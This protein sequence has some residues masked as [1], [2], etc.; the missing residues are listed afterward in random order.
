MERKNA[1]KSPTRSR[2][3]QEEW[4]RRLPEM[5]SLLERFPSAFEAAAARRRTSL[6]PQWLELVSNMRARVHEASDKELGRQNEDEP[7]DSPAAIRD[8]NWSHEI[9][10]VG[11]MLESVFEDILADIGFEDGAS[12]GS[13]N[14]VRHALSQLQMELQDGCEGYRHDATERGLRVA[15]ALKRLSPSYDDINMRKLRALELVGVAARWVHVPSAAEVEEAVERYK[16]FASGDIERHRDFVAID[17]PLTSATL[18]HS[19][20]AD[21]DPAFAALDPL[22]V[23]EELNEARVDGDGGKD[24]GGDGRMGPVRALARLSMM[25]GAFGFSPRADES[26][27]DAVDRA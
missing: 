2:E 17:K 15:G 21:I 14:L 24:G 3:R 25:C 1:A 7:Q 13:I 27:D 19:D 16:E 9:M 8:S 23:L 6:P 22:V 11:D 4:R 26:F 18:A 12:L 20:L 5:T 10:H